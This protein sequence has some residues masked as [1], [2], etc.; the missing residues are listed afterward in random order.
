M[1]N[2]IIATLL[3]V[4]IVLGIT[5]LNSESRETNNQSNDSPSDG[6]VV[7]D[8]SANTESLASRGLTTLP[9]SIFDETNTTTL[10]VSNNN[11]TGALPAEIRKLKKLQIL[12]ASNNKLTGIPAEIGQLENLETVDFSNNDISGLPLEIG[13]LSNLKT[14]DLRGN[15]NVSTY[16][17]GLIQK[18]IPNAAILTD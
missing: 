11:L 17:I 8:L 12:N 10:D 1:K 14:L 16:D 5:V 7:K 9:M 6:E 13:N 4:T 3:I 2:I 15:Q 18:E